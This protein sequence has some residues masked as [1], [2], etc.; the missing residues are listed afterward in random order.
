MRRNDR[1]PRIAV[2]IT[3]RCAALLT[4]TVAAGACRP[5]G[6]PAP[7]GPVALAIAPE[8]LTAPLGPAAETVTVAATQPV[9]AA[10]APRP[11][12]DAERF[13]FRQLYETLLRADC[14]GRVLPALAVEWRAED[15]GR[16]WTFTLRDDAA[17]WDGVPVTAADVRAAWA[18]AGWSGLA[19][20]VVDA[21]TLTATL[22]W[23]AAAA[24]FAHPD[25]AVAKRVRESPWPLGTGAYWVGGAAPRARAVVAR[26]VRGAG[27][28]LVLQADARPDARD[29][30]D[31]G[32]DLLLVRERSA[33]AYARA[34]TEVRTLALPWDRTYGLLVP[35]R[36]GTSQR[37][38]ALRDFREALARDAVRWD[39]REALPPFWWDDLE[40]GAPPAADLPRPVVG[41]AARIVYPREDV[42]ARGL[43]ERLA[44]LASAG[45][46]PHEHVLPALV[47]ALRERG[48]AVIARGL[49]DAAL[50]RALG[51]GAE[52]A[53]VLPLPRPALAPC[54]E[55][56]RLRSAAPWIGGAALAR[57]LVPLVDVRAHLVIR[58]LP[59]QAAVEWD[60]VPRIV[61]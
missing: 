61:P 25:L 20:T 59:A 53:Y 44:A 32:A 33:L 39:A 40:C 57:L 27:P 43:A 17:F 46:G 56:D 30:L 8:C 47:P 10:H 42:A 23:P 50:A 28:D 12:T 22:A 48:A 52:L 31:A 26:P 5:D 1:R 16:R 38:A 4:V 55:W 9:D 24:A 11:R 2:S 3:A 60:G 34:A 15:G 49:D 35:S 14:T 51:R 29:A 54:R 18:E 13:L 7:P 19:V 6:R 41:P 45:A 58:T 21:R 37:D 36:I